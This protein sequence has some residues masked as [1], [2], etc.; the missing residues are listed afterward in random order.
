MTP[1]KALATLLAVTLSTG[2][3]SAQ[4]WPTGTIQIIIPSRPGGGTDIMG[5]IFADYL[6]QATNNPVVVVNQPTG[7]GIVAQEEV[8]TA[9]PDGLTMLFQHTG[10]LV[11]YQTGLYD[12]PYT[13]F[14]ILGIAQSYPPQVYAV[15]ADA[16]WETIADFVADARAHP[17]QYTVGVSL[18]QTTHFIAG[19]LMA[20]EDVDLRLVEASAEVDKVAGIQGGH[21]TL[22]NLGAGPARQYVQSGDMRVLCLVN[23]E[24]DPR[25]PEFQTC[26]EQGVDVSWIAPL[27]ILGP[28]GMD[29]AMTEQ[30]NAVIRAMGDDPQVQERLAAADSAFEPYD[31]AAAHDLVAGEDATIDRL[32]RH[33][34]LSAH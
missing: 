27:L 30:I 9:D 31:L 4:D 15:A 13:D 22:G 3:A 7:S 29:P 34:G 26:R 1:R 25:Y 16:P 19:M 17:G 11:G 23:P 12:H 6:Q 32:A 20:N 18:G 21:I 28:A 24:A 2:A 8:R 5:R 10:M 14:T 33:L